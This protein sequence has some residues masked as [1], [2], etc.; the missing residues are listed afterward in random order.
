MNPDGAVSASNL[1]VL[2]VEFVTDER[3]VY[4]ARLFPFIQGAVCHLGGKADWFC[5]G[6]DVRTLTSKADGFLQ[7]VQLDA[8]SAQRL[9]QAA[10]ALLPT[11]ILLTHEPCLELVSALQRISPKAQFLALTDSDSEGSVQTLYQFLRGTVPTTQRRRQAD[12]FEQNGWLMAWLGADS[13]KA[14]AKTAYIADAWPPNYACTL[15]NQ[16]VLESPPRIM[17]PGGITCDFKTPVASEP[18]YASLDLSECVHDFG[19]A[20]CTWY[21]GPSSDLARDPLELCLRQLTAMVNTPLPSRYSNRVHLMDIRL[22]HRLDALADA[23]LPLNLPPTRFFFEPR[24]DRVVQRAQ[25]L[26]RFVQRLSVQGHFVELLRMGAENLVPSENQ[27]LHKQISLE[28]QD[29]AMGL[30][31]GLKKSFPNH[32]DFDPNWG[33]ITCTPWTT[34]EE[35]HEGLLKG[36]ERG[37]DPKGVWLYTPLQLFI[38]SPVLVLAQQD[39]GVL[40]QEWED[41]AFLYQPAANN[42]SL[43]SLQPWRFKDPRMATAFA[44]TVRFSAA[45]LQDKIDDTVLR[46]DPLYEAILRTSQ[47]QEIFRRPDLFALQVVQTLLAGPSQSDTFSILQRALE[48]YGQFAEIRGPAVPEFGRRQKLEFLAKAVSSRNPR[49]GSFRVESVWEEPLTPTDPAGPSA[50]RMTLAIGPVT[51]DLVLA[52]LER[53]P[54]HYLRTRKLAVSHRSPLPNRAESFRNLLLEYLMIFEAAVEKHAPELLPAN[55]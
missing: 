3:W 41:A 21:R 22:F 23:L 26:E 48:A 18:A 4:A 49:F 24:A 42:I 8:E 44:L 2:L 47:T 11:H 43:D 17:A 30:L 28:Q 14:P 29:L 34:L 32:F 10:Q 7:C 37:F 27:R 9:E 46:K 51:F 33:Y 15:A 36:M 39:V 45:A 50:I 31:A 13:T 19:C 40:S 38:G 6:A 1:R 20:F 54:K 55:Q 52:S 16:R 5:F 35:F 12:L 53:M 25:E